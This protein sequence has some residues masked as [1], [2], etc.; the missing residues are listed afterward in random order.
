[1]PY[2][3]VRVPRQLLLDRGVPVPAR[4]VALTM[5]LKANRAGFVKADASTIGR[6]V[7]L[8][9][10]SVRRH[11]EVL[12][13]NGYLIRRDHNP[14]CAQSE[15]GLLIGHMLAIQP[16]GLESADFGETQIGSNAYWAEVIDL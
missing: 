15:R 11:W 3:I 14:K 5:Y 10:N 4:L 1:M 8:H 7:G 12:I 9:P 13:E 2:P 16:G 6:L